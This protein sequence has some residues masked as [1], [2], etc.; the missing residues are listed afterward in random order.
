MVCVIV[1][2]DLNNRIGT[3]FLYKTGSVQLYSSD[4]YGMNHIGSCQIVSF[5]LRHS[6]KCMFYIHFSINDNKWKHF[7]IYTTIFWS[8]LCE[9]STFSCGLQTSGIVSS[10][11]VFCIIIT[12]TE[13]LA[14]SRYI[15]KSLAQYS[16]CKN[17]HSKEEKLC[18][19]YHQLINIKAFRDIFQAFSS[20]MHVNNP[21]FL[22]FRDLFCSRC[23]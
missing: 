7:E 9:T 17:A 13:M 18:L 19:S 8:V 2:S 22:L 6:R 12:L 11:T 3:I 23:S 14:C 4:V 10:S 21:S 20:F 5:H 1:K 15:C 16:S